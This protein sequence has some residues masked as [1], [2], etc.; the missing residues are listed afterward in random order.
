M[1]HLQCGAQVFDSG[2]KGTGDHPPGFH[3]QNRTQPLASGENTVAH[4]SM[5]GNRMLCRRRQQAFQCCVGQLSACL[6]GVFEHD[7]EYSKCALVFAV[8]T[9]VAK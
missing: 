2:G 5:N 4:R 1:K 9:M 6:Q 3:T 7:G 8:T